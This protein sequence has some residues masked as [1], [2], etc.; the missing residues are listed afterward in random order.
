MLNVLEF[1]HGFY[2]VS[3][4]LPIFGLEFAF[5]DHF[6][7]EPSVPV[8]FAKPTNAYQLVLIEYVLRISAFDDSEWG[9]RLHVIIII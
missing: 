5:V 4:V 9:F 8:H 1:P 6:N 7:G 3:E 2:F